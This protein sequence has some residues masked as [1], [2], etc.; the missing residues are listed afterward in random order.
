M[1]QKDLYTLRDKAVLNI[2]RSAVQEVRIQTGPDS[3]S[4][5]KKDDGWRMDDQR[6]KL[7]KKRWRNSW[8]SW[9]L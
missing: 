9:I 2:Q 6:P 8:M 3:F 7:I 1:M 5:F 4:L